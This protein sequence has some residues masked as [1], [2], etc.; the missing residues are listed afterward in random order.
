LLSAAEQI[1]RRSGSPLFS[2]WIPHNAAANRELRRTLGNA[3]YEAAFSAGVHWREED[4]TN[5]ASAL[6]REFAAN[7]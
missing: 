4:A 3:D 7:S 5:Q 2:F 1:R 6:L